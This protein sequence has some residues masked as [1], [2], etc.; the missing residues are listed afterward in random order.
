MRNH[1]SGLSAALA[2][3]LST[4][5]PACAAP[6]AGEDAPAEGEAALPELGLL[7]TI[8]VYWGESGGMS[9]ALAGAGTPHWARAQLELSYRLQPLDVLDEASLAPLDNLLLAQPRAFSAQENVAL[10]AWVR[11][12]GKLLL[13]ADPL[14]TGES[15]YSIGDRRRPQDV[16]LLSPLLTH[17]GLELEFVEDQPAGLATRD[18][19]G[20][21]LP[22]NLPGR[23]T[24]SASGGHC[25]LLAEGLLARCALGAGQ[26]TVL[27]DAALL[28]L[29]EPHPAAAGALAWLV[30]RAFAENGDGAGQRAQGRVK[31]AISLAFEAAAHPLPGPDRRRSPVHE[32]GT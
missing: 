15:R 32:A 23:F 5:V 12:G 9:E 31:P 17:W 26:A 19:A 8:P 24:R 27:A 22:V 29:H 1:R 25:T 16:I 13:L 21:P 30:R 6:P 18:I 20:T 14:L 11:R 2:V 4:A 28:D 7:G 3:L 10:D